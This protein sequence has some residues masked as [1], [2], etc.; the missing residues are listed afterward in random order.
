[1]L[2]SDLVIVRDER[3]FR[4]VARALPMRLNS[5]NR[6]MVRKGQGLNAS[7]CGHVPKQV[8]PQLQFV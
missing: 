8:E 5:A 6:K 7:A 4:R 1:M 3:T 2:G